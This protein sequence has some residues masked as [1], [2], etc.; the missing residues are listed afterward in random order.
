MNL[1]RAGILAIFVLKV[2]VTLIV[3]PAIPDL[4]PSHWNFDGEVDGYLPRSWGV[5][6]IPL[7]SFTRHAGITFF[8]NTI[9]SPMDRGVRSRE[10]RNYLLICGA[11]DTFLQD[12]YPARIPSGE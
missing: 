2:A 3:Y 6:I 1:V 5:A 10:C 8:T 11:V 7:A 9:F 12:R 4:I